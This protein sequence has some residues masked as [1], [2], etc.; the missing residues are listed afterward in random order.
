LANSIVMP[1]HHQ[2]ANIFPS[3][4]CS[5]PLSAVTNTG[6]MLTQELATCSL[7]KT[8]ACY[9]RTSKMLFKPEI[10][11]ILELSGNFNKNI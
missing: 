6:S 7:L 3:S 10:L 11:D 5:P 9:P 2:R 8:S 4:L 1:S